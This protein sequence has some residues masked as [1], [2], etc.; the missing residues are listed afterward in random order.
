MQQHWQKQQKLEGA[1]AMDFSLHKVGELS[2]T[3]F[4]V[5]SFDQLTSSIWTG[6]LEILGRDN[7]T[8]FW[9]KI[10]VL[11]ITEIVTENI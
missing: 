4:C 5:N 11:K 2:E 6:L 10:M 3:G 7:H 8:N 9:N 1:N